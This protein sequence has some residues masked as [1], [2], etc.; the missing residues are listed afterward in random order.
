MAQG[1][2]LKMGGAESLRLRRRVGVSWWRTRG[3]RESVSD[4]FPSLTTGAR[5][6]P[7]PTILP[8]P[9]GTR[10]RLTTR[11]ETWRAD[12]TRIIVY[13]KY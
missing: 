6:T 9:L 12:K 13:K 7:P 8:A 1:A 10:W 5:S 11:Q 3:Q 4:W 2:W